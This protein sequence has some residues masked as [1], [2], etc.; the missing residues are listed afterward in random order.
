METGHDILFFWVARMCQM[1][2]LL[3]DKLPFN[4]CYLHSI[5]R[6]ERGE[7]M[8]KSKE[9]IID[10]MEV[11]E[12]CSLEILIQKINDSTLPPKEK[13]KGITLK[14]KNFASGIP[15][16]GS[17]A[18]RFGILNMAHLGKDIN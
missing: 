9:N 16:C 17:D 13:E 8:S 7:K 18:L 1:G 15:E 2:L 10:P 5:I 6:D 14:K 11:I 12:G 3:T 4:K